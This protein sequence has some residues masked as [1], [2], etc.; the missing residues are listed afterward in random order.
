MK[1]TVGET[2]VP[3]ICGGVLVQNGDLVVGGRDGVA[4]IAKKEI[5]A[6]LER[7]EA[8]AQKEVRVLEEL[9]EGRTT[10]EIYQFTKIL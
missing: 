6:V 3:V 9:K 10:A 5:E 8:I 4:V 7:A 2:A 1:E